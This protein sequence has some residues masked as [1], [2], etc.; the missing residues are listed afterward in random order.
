MS[1]IDLTKN[2]IRYEGKAT[3]AQPNQPVLKV[4]LFVEEQL[5]EFSQCYSNSNIRNEKGLT[6][7]LLR[8]LGDK[9]T[10]I[11]PFYFIKEDIEDVTDGH[12]P[13]VD[14]GVFAKQEVQIEAKTCKRRDRFFTFEAKILGLDDKTREK[15]YLTGH[16]EKKQG[17]EKYIECGGIERF[18]NGKHGSNLFYAGMIGYVLKENFHFWYNQINSWINEEIQIA[19]NKSIIWKEEDKLICQPLDSIFLSKYI[20]R[21]LRIL[22]VEN[23]SIIQIIHLWVGLQQ[24]S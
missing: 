10:D 17:K 9:L 6:H 19:T 8:L 3:F 12:S 1:F 24:T 20:S 23:T 21:N 16:F 18:K 4:L 2:Q 7:E 22:S 11:Y 13:S 15:E 5:K 14:I